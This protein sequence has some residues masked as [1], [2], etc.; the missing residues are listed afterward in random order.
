[1]NEDLLSKV[2][3]NEMSQGGTER[4]FRELYNQ[5]PRALV[6]KFQI[7]P[8]RYRPDL[9]DLS[10]IQLLHVDD[11]PG[12]PMYNHLLNN[13]WSKFTKLIFVSHWQMQL[14]INAYRI[15][16][17]KCAVLLN[18]IEPIPA[19]TKPTDKIRLMYYSTPQRGLEILVPVFKE[20]SKKDERLELVVASNFKLYGN[21]ARNAPFLQLFEECKQD[22]KIT[23]LGTV[24]YAEI[25]HHI[26]QSHILAYPSIW[27]ETSCMVLM[28]AMSGGLIAVHPDFAALPETAANCTMMYHF[29]EDRKEHVQIFRK[30]L[31]QAIESRD[32]LSEKLADQ[33]K[34]AD[35]MYSWQKRIPQWISFLQGL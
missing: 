29:H 15:P 7:W 24:T 18:A 17:S 14:F 28:E 12:D 20:L 21:E 23:Y 31:E 2:A 25:I 13:G 11:L 1:M 26:Q 8:S 4:L 22:P 34:Y 27:A 16:W 32:Q 6:E 9:V 3:L 33:K 35:T 30:T 10:K 19:H 5:L